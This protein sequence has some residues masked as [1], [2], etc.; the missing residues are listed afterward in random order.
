MCNENR[1]L[2]YI[3]MSGW[4]SRR[5]PR[6]DHGWCTLP[7]GEHVGGWRRDGIY[8][9]AATI[10]K[11]DDEEAVDEGPRRT[12]KLPPIC[13]KC[14][15]LIK[16]PLLVYTRPSTIVAATHSSYIYILYNTLG[17]SA[18]AFFVI[19]LPQSSLSV[20]LLH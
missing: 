8:D 9:R 4:V 12:F 18:H 1:Y 17:P 20:V 3:Y 11:D 19:T 6:R 7:D 13:L 2:I 10:G 16:F 14:Q 5:C 15:T